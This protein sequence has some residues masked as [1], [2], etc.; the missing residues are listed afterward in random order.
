MNSTVEPAPRRA[1]RMRARAEAA[2]QTGE[3]ILD[4]AWAAFSK[5]SFDRI[6]LQHIAAEAGVTVQ[7]IIRRF[8]SKEGLFEATSRR[9]GARIL[10]ERQPSDPEE[11]GLEAAVQA[12]VGH[13]ERDG[14]TV[15]HFL[16]QEE[17]LPIVAD[18]VA[19][20][21]AEHRSWIEQHCASVLEGA[22]GAERDR[23]LTAAIAATDLYV[24]KL[25]RLDLGRSRRH[26][27]QAMLTLLKGIPTTKEGA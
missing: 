9:E 15:L 17:R 5:Q 8:G 10:A 12:L 7:T 13:Y 25:L 19:R 3:R 24:W 27:E 11:D 2:Q 16:R 26:V 1:Y 14:R 20:G 22:T 6:T 4:A 18:I 23:L 21:R